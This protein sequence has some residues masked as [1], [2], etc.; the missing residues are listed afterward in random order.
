MSPAPL[1][2]MTLRLMVCTPNSYCFTRFLSVSGMVPL[3]KIATGIAP[4]LSHGVAVT[5]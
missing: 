2:I 4:F 1:A 5:F 3:P